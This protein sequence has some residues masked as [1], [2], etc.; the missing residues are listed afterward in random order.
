MAP[1]DP[2]G[3]RRV[4]DRFEIAVVLALLVLLAVLVLIAT[5]EAVAALVRALAAGPALALGGDRLLDLFGLVLLVLMGLELLSALRAYLDSHTIHVELVL[6]LALVAVA[7]KVITIDLAGHPALT[8]LS[9]AGL[10]VALAAAL[11]VARRLRTRGDP[12]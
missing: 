3:L 8:W 7:R 5:A 9:V 6:E 12:T 4:V 2:H 10:V 1:D 11:A